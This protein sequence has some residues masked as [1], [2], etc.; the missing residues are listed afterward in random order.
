MAQL[1]DG[2]REFVAALP[3]RRR[4]D[5]ATLL[6][7]A[8]PDFWALL[9]GCL[10]LAPGARLDAPSLLRLPLFAALHDEPTDQDG[11]PVL[12]LAWKGQI[13]LSLVVLTCVVSESQLS[14][15]EDVERLLQGELQEA[16]LQRQARKQKST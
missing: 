2:A 9:E 15:V 8:S 3:A 11:V 14:T 4:V 13:C 10:A 6:P 1:P 16:E 7:R 5:W 12:V